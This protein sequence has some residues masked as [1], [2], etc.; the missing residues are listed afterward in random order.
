MKMHARQIWGLIVRLIYAACLLG[1]T[2]NHAR[3]VAAHG[4]VWD[5]GG[6]PVAS[7]AFWT[8]LTLLDPLAALLLIARP[9]AGVLATAVIIFSDVIHNLWMTARYAQPH[10]LLIA[11]TSDL[12]VISQIAFLLFVAATAPIAWTRRGRS[13][14]TTHG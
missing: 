7:A 4:L 5:Y 6:V 14:P 11:V 1:A 8:S 10:H 9:N 3:I 13:L 12:F 2:I